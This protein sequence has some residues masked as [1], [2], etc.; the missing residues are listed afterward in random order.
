MIYDEFCEVTVL[1]VSYISKKCRGKYSS[2]VCSHWPSVSGNISSTCDQLRG[3][4]VQHFVRHRVLLK[5]SQGMEENIN[6]LLAF[7]NWYRVHPRE[8][9]FHPCI[10]VV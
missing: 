4:V 6:N 1:G 8:K 7:L 3:A 10:Q 5:S 9:W 2:A